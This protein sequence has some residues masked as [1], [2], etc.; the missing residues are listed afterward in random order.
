M[1]GVLL[2]GGG[3]IV[4]LIS[5][6]AN[7]SAVRNNSLRTRSREDKFMASAIA[8]LLA[9]L[10]GA[11]SAPDLLVSGAST[12]YYA[13]ALRPTMAALAR[14]TASPTRKLMLAIAVAPRLQCA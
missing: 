11:A 10:S 6:L 3:P 5:V 8:Q 7:G 14:A 9:A 2:L 12:A 4:T 13:Y 1:R